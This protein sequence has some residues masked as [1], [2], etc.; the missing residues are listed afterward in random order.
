MFLEQIGPPSVD[1]DQERTGANKPSDLTA[2]EQQED[3]RV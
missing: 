3:A 2:P 1:R